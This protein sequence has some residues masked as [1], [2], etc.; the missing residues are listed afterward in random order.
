MKELKGFERITLKAGESRDVSF[1]ITA[2]MLSFYNSE[3]Q[4]VAEPGEFEI[5]VGG[6]SRDVQKN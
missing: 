4:L 6:N 2:D 3:L 5:M 1:T